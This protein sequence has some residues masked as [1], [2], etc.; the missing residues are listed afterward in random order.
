MRALSSILVALVAAILFAAALQAGEFD[1]S[2]I[3]SGVWNRAIKRVITT[4]PCCGACPVLRMKDGSKIYGYV[5]GKDPNAEGRN[6][7]EKHKDKILEAVKF[8]DPE[9]YGKWSNAAPAKEE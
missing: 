9:E 1:G 3:D 5:T 4:P 6:L 7:F 8:I 2:R